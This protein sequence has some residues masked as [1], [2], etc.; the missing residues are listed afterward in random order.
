MNYQAVIF[1]LFGTLIPSFSEKEYRQTVMQTA[2]ILS[3][4]PEEYWQLWAATFD[5]S[6]LGIISDYEA[7]IIH[8]C[9]KMELNPKMDKIRKATKI[10]FDYE[11]TTMIPRQEAIGVLSALKIKGYKIG[12]ITDCSFEATAIWKDTALAPFFDVTIF[13]CSVGLRKPDPR[14]YHLALNKLGVESRLSLYIGDG[15][16]RELTGAT[17]VGMQ[18]IQLRTPGEDS[19]D[20]YRVNKEDWQGAIIK[21]LT[22]VLAL[23]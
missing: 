9:Q 11:K 18:A 5:D 6:I 23:V 10:L 15:S 14:I 17:Q 8:I 20:V 21:S 16:S 22:D 13:S 3:A 2:T 12:L 1:D 7:K 19:P 4:T